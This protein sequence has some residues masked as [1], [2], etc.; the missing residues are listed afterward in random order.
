ME[1]PPKGTKDGRYRNSH[2]S[3]RKLI[4][5][6]VFPAISLQDAKISRDKA[7]TLVAQGKYPSEVQ[8]DDIVVT[9]ITSMN[10]FKVI[11]LEWLERQILAESIRDKAK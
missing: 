4:S 8:Q 9:Q 7:N 1:V 11:P 2:G 10:T 5:M 6:G 3:K